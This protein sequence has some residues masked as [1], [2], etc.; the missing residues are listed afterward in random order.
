MG[1]IING[2][3]DT[4]GPVD[5][6]MSLLGTVGIGGTMTIEDF[7]NI[8]SVGLVTARNGLRVDGDYLRVN[9]NVDSALELNA[10]DDGPVY[11]SLRRSGTRVAYY[12][13]GGSG[14]T[15]NI[16][17]EV[18]NGQL[19]IDTPSHFS[20]NTNNA[21]RL[22]ITSAGDMGLGTASPRNITNFGSFAINGTAGAFTDYFL[23][24]TRT[25]TTAVDSNGFT[26]EAVGSSTPFRVITNGTEKLRI[27]SSGN[28]GLGTSSPNVTG[29]GSKVAT[30]NIAS[31]SNGGLEITKNNVAAGHFTVESAASNDIRIG[32]V[33]GSAALTFQTGG[34][35]RARI[36]S[37]GNLNL[38]SSS[39]TLIDLNFT[40][41]ALNVYARV[42]G[43]KS[44][45][46]VGDLRFHTYSGGLSEQARISSSGQLLLGTTDAGINS[47][48][49]LTIADS[50]HCGLTIRSGTSSQGNIFFSDGTSG[51]SEYDGY[52]QYQQDTQAMLFG[53]GG[54]TERLRIDSA[55]HI[56]IG[57]NNP[58]YELEV[59]SSDTTTFNITAGGNTNLSRLFFSDDDAVAR[60][61]LN[62]DHQADS[63]LIATAGSERLRITSDGRVAINDTSAERELSVRNKTSGTPN[64][65][66][67][68]HT[69]DDGT[70]TSAY[71]Q[72]EFKHGSASS[73]WIWKQGQNTS[74]YGGSSSMNYYNSNDSSHSF[75]TNGNN[76]R[77][78]VQ[79]GDGSCTVNMANAYGQLSIQQRSD[80]HPP[81]SIRH[82]DGSLYKEMGTVGPTDRNGSDA[83]GGGTYLHVR[84][85]TVWN[86]SSMT[87]FRITGFYPYSDYTH[88]Y[89]GM[90][91]YGQSA[92]RTNPYGQTISN[93]K[94]ATIHS[95][96][97]EA[98]SPGYLVFV[99][100]W[101]TN[102]TGLMFEHIGAGSVYGA[103]MQ[104]DIEI[105]D[106]LRSTGTSALTF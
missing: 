51:N 12:G 17:N 47:G 32:A 80:L 63:L 103:Y 16:T 43:G 22:R 23:N 81:L 34:S 54:G 71:A 100:D 57:I 101:P 58:A 87:L 42:E 98:A 31:G 41:S 105:I 1:I 48:D 83:S 82:H 3:N 7:T 35:E 24:G 18:A 49:N 13:F 45:S 2:Q 67:R 20:V 74:S 61:Y 6:T 77:F 70:S 79:G 40:D 4:I 56:G 5:N 21:E 85:R 55:G 62:Y 30:I 50:G 78:Q 52:I 95:I 94:R 65:T 37:S 15:F 38:V 97:N 93:L 59:A 28:F 14:S 86:D 10:T 76:L 89:V 60:G 73:S 9:T 44:G 91:R 11:S 75:F 92:Y 19:I 68:V 88:S 104:N 99:C 106:S 84:V 29:F 25:G 90:Y 96:Y 66:I 39:S 27:D 8:D 26:S 69:D 33:G 46:G 64:S 102:Y 36:D 53:T 72:L